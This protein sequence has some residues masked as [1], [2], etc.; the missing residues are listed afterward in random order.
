MKKWL[1]RLD[2]KL[3]G[4]SRQKKTAV[5][6]TLCAVLLLLIWTRFG[7]PLPSLEME[8]RRVERINLLP[9]SEII[10]S[11]EGRGR[12][13]TREGEDRSV[14]MHQP[15][16]LGIAGGRVTAAV[17]DIT[18]RWTAE[19][20]PLEEGPTPA[21]FRYAHAVLFRPG[22]V[23]FVFPMMFVNVPEGAARGEF[24][25]TL[26]DRET[27]YSRS[28]QGWDTGNGT[29]LFPMETPSTGYSDRWWAGGSY[30][31]TLYRADGSLLLEKIGTLRAE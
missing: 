2:R 21:P 14:N 22:V 19:T 1:N 3:D 9:R 20:Y 17:Y 31:L 25:L 11:D 15:T 13:Y 29:W 10:F 28:G 24:S 23:E 30:T 5:N 18:D 16:F 26:P 7:C 12:S 8:F 4:I 27:N 6:L